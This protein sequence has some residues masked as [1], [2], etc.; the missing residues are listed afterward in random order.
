MIKETVVITGAGSGIGRE[1]ARLFHRDGARV[2][3]VS[4]VQEELSSL[5]TELSCGPGE[6]VTLRKDLSLPESAQEVFDWI[7]SSVYDVDVLINNAGYGVMGEH[8][9]L[10]YDKI[11]RMLTLNMVTLTGLSTL[12]GR[13]MRIKGEGK[14][15]SVASTTSFQ[16]L[17][18]LSAYAATKHYVAAFSEALA[19]EL[20]P[21][22][23]TVTCLCPGTTDTPF[24]SGCGVDRNNRR[25]SVGQ[26]AFSVAM[27]PAEVAK[28]G[29]RALR[30]GKNKSIPGV[31]NKLHWIITGITPNRIITRIVQA[32]F[33]GRPVN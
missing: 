25:G 14:I 19:R 16:P 4:L 15:M 33:R 13:K 2:I 22:K 23:I 20:A 24:L 28:T 6:I 27:T 1:F 9:D 3:A 10:D 30:A 21:Y 11:Q 12:L 32:F 5:E 29:Y 17:P 8:L 7:E 18:Y 26:I 31:L